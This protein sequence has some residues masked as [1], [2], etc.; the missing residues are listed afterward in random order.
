MARDM[1]PDPAAQVA[2]I[3]ARHE[4]EERNENLWTEGRAMQACADRATLLHL[5]DRAGEEMAEKERARKHWH[6]F[7][8]AEREWR[9]KAEAEVE[10]LRNLLAGSVVER[11]RLE[12]EVA[13]L[14][15]VLAAI[16]IAENL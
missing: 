8:V 4:E 1:T 9:D 3:R 7:Y 5:L 12:A 14:R 10:K 11:G 2:A 16:S 13:R 15:D 6:E